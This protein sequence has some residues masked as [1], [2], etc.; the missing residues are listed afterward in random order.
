MQFHITQ[1]NEAIEPG[2]GDSF[3]GLGKSKLF[4]SFFQKHSFASDSFGM[5]SA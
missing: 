3:D 2:V 5:F 4:D 1:G